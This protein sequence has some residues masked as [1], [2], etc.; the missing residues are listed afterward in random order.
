M[1]NSKLFLLKL[2]IPLTVECWTP[3]KVH[4]E[5]EISIILILNMQ[6]SVII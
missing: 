3:E 5:L 4:L 6:A 2:S 1:L